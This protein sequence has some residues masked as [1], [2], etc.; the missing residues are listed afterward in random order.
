MKTLRASVWLL[1]LACIVGLGSGCASNKI[2]W[3]SRVGSYTYDDAVRE[4]GPPD[5]AAKLSDGSTVADWLT[6]RGMRTA[7][8]Y[9]SFG[10]YP[11][12]YG[13]GGPAYTVVDP[14]SPDRFMRLTFDPQ[15][16]LASWERVYR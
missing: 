7:T 15:G 1:L 16:V 4:L 5:K 2:D 6:A 3:A 13:W 14:P 12:R 11:Y 9:G 10:H 8:T